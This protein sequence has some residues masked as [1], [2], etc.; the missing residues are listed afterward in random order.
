MANETAV[1]GIAGKCVDKII[2]KALNTS[3]RFSYT[4]CTILAAISLTGISLLYRTFL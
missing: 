4:D 3:A 1:F 2:S